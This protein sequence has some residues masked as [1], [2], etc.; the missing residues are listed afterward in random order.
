MNHDP[1]EALREILADGW[2]VGGAVRDR[3]LGRSVSDFDVVLAGD[4]EEP[5]RRLAKALDAHRF[6]LSEGFGAW[7]VIAR[8]RS[9]LVDLMAAAGGSIEADLARR[10][11][12][13]NAI[14]QPLDAANTEL[15]DPYGGVG[16]LDARRLRM[17]SA[18]SFSD[19]PLRVMRLARHACELGFAADGPTLAAASDAAPA[20]SAVASERVFA[21]LK[22]IVAAPAAVGGLGVMEEVGATEVVLPEL[23]ALHGIEQSHYHHLDVHGHT[24][25]VLAETI[26]LHRASGEHFGDEDGEAIAA[27]LAE[28]LADGLSRGEALRFGAL[29]HDIAKPQ[30][31]AVTDSGRVTFMGHDVAG[32]QL[33]GELF[34]RLRSSERL[35]EHVAA[36]T[37]EHLRLGFLVHRAPLDRRAVYEYMRATEPVA[38][39]VSLLSV[40]DRLATRGRNSDPAIFKHI[41]LARTLIEEGLRWRQAPPHPPV[42]GDELARAIGIEPGPRLGELLRELE[43]ASYAG[44]VASAGDAIALA[45]EL[46]ARNG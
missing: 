46:L 7:R 32:A 18:E 14:A 23:A 36:L 2:L 35:A 4:V 3:L 39:D 22:R 33:V 19:D 42:R 5:A 43:Q 44:E 24:M 13:I 31:R 11:L 15:L 9:W 21:E 45:R 28:P 29:F 41:E 37:R 26:A 6:R 8:D 12:T 34:G 27:L 16:D 17:V 25:L 1:L 38:V 20:L 30:T 40:A 10:D